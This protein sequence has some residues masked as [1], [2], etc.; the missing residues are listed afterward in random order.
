MQPQTVMSSLGRLASLNVA[1]PTY[2]IEVVDLILGEATLV[3][4]SDI[5]LLPT[6]TGLEVLYRIDG[7]LQLAGKLPKPLL[8]N[9]VA[10]LKL[11]ANMITYRTDIP[12]EGRILESDGDVERRVSTFPTH[13][14]EKVVIRM[15]GGITQFQRLEDLKLPEGIERTLSGLLNETSGAILFTG[16]AGS[17]KTTTLY[18]CL[19]ELSLASRGGRSLMTLE[20]PIEMLVPGVAQAQIN[21]AAGLDLAVGLRSMMRQDPEVIG[22][23]E[24]RDLA[25]AEVAL[26]ASLTG[27]LL[28]CTFHAG[29]AAAV[30][31]RLAEMGIEPYVIISGVRAI[32][33]QRLV[34]RLCNCARATEDPNEL[35]GL[36]IPSAWVT[37]GCS[38]CR[39]T[40]YRGRVVMAEIL[41]P[42]DRRIR[43]AIRAH[44]D[45]ARLEAMAVRSGMVRLSER[46]RQAVQAGLTDPAEFRRVLGISTSPFPSSV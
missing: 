27:H 12:Q 38:R 9:V 11:L 18:T 2:V 20:D 43:R 34:R 3:S 26:Q 39:G 46:A 33:C 19:R 42:H 17:G 24:I 4:A 28:L 1:S 6:A 31:G 36:D 7:V 37:V 32:V 45:V 23:G 10:R 5:H 15:F 35:L 14:G 25:T 41:N 8:P 16:P 29:S 40:G 22:V 13:F 30:I 21:Q 44:A